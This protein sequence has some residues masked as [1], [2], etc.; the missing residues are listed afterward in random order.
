MKTIPL[1]R[2]Y[3]AKVDDE[4]YMELAKARWYADIKGNGVYAKRRVSVDGRSRI[5]GM[6]RFL[7]GYPVG[8][9][10]DHINGDTLDNRKS[11]LRV[12]TN[13]ENSRN[14]NKSSSNKSGYK[15]VYWSK[16]KNKWSVEV[17]KDYK[18]HYGGSFD[19]LK[20][21]VISYNNLSAK[22][23]GEFFRPNVYR[24]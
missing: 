1:T 9:Q 12:C 14:R 2:G 17:I 22:L 23:F 19:N 6:H 15:G 18:K 7:M 4:D 8:L 16:Q 21:A 20:D 13:S 24:E 3:F 5:V 11:N 10:V